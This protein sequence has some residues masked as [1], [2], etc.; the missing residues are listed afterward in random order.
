MVKLRGTNV[1]PMACLGAVTGD[2][3][4]TGEWLCLVERRE[5]GL[6]IRE[7]M[8]VKVEVKEGAVDREGLTAKLQDRLRSDLGVKVA[9]ELVPAGA[10]AAYTY[11]RE[12]KAKRLLDRRFEKKA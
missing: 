11:G 5:S 7:E 2:D 1:F 10:L 12:G 9:V 4:T 6:D 8:T 3:R